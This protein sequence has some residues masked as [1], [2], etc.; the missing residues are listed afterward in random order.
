M[1]KK[2]SREDAIKK[3]GL[4][5]EP[6]LGELDLNLH[7]PHTLAEK[8]AQLAARTVSGS[9]TV[10]ETLGSAQESFHFRTIEEATAALAAEKR[11]EL[12]D[13]RD[14]LNGLMLR[15]HLENEAAAEAGKPLPLDS[16]LSAAFEK[17]A[18]ALDKIDEILAN[19]F[20]VNVRTLKDQIAVPER[21]LD[22]GET[23]YVL[24]KTDTLPVLTMETVAARD[25]SGFSP[26]GKY[27]VSVSY[28]FGKA[29]AP[30]PEK[31]SKTFVFAAED[32]QNRAPG[33]VATAAN[34]LAF[35]R[36]TD[37][38]AALRDIVSDKLDQLDAERQSL[39]NALRSEGLSHRKPRGPQN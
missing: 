18:A 3:Y 31:N 28:I 13:R 21:I 26:F 30:V 39:V 15:S 10:V 5:Y 8:I 27:D 34:T 24:R 9:I 20:T 35:T 4:H 25:I 2:I 12:E 14:T 11:A 1:P 36:S 29:G 37:A 33:L 7:P 17:A 38:K 16:S 6:G 22:V 32:Q 23:V 19:D